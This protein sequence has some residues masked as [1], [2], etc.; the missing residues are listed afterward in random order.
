[1]IRR[2]VL[3]KCTASALHGSFQLTLIRA[4]LGGPDLAAVAGQV[5]FVGLLCFVYLLMCAAVLL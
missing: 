5:M 2:Q 3:S 4:K 1:M